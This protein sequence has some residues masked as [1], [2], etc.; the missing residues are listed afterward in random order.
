ML[1]L[2]RMFIMSLKSIMNS[3]VRRGGLFSTSES[4]GSTP[5]LCAGGPSI[6]MFIHKI[7]IAFNGLGKWN[8]VEKAINDSAEM[9]LFV[10]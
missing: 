5:K 9:L 3:S 7:C 1:A 8:I 4:T 6:I 10:Y 2:M